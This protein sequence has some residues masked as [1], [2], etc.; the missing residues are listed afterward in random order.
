M[1]FSS[2]PAAGAAPLQKPGAPTGHAHL[3]APASPRSNTS[4]IEADNENVDEVFSNPDTADFE[5]RSD[6]TGATSPGP[7]SPGPSSPLSRSVLSAAMASKSIP[8]LSASSPP[9]L[10]LAGIGAVP[11]P[12]SP[13]Q[14]IRQAAYPESAVSLPATTAP[15]SPSA[16]AASSKK[17]APFTSNRSQAPS[18][19]SS[20]SA[21][22]SLPSAN[23]LPS[24]PVEASTVSRLFAHPPAPSPAITPAQAVSPPRT[25]G[26]SPRA[27]ASTLLPLGSPTIE[28]TSAMARAPRAATRPSSPDSKIRSEVSASAGSAAPHPTRKSARPT[29]SSS[30]A[31]GLMGAVPSVPTASN[32]TLPAGNNSSPSIFERDIE[33]RDAGHIMSQQEA[34]DV[35]IPSVLDDAVEA[36][37]EDST[38]QIEIVAPQAPPPPLALSS[39]A[40]SV[41]SDASSSVTP[42]MSPAPLSSSGLVEAPPGSIAA[43]IAERLGT[44]QP[45]QDDSRQASASSRKSLGHRRP[46]SDVSSTTSFRSRSPVAHRG[47][48][49]HEVFDASPVR[50]RASASP[51]PGPAASLAAAVSQATRT[52]SQIASA[53]LGGSAMG[54]TT[55]GALSPVPTATAFPS[56]PLPNPY[57]SSSPNLAVIN[58]PLV[59]TGSDAGRPAASSVSIDGA[60]ISGSEVATMDQSLDTLADVIA[61]SEAEEAASP[62]VPRSPAV[63]QLVSGS[64]S[65]VLERQKARQS[66]F[67]GTGLGGL[68]SLPGGLGV[69]DSRDG[70]FQAL[71]SGTPSPSQEKRRL[72]FFSYADILNQNPGEVMDFE[73]A[74]RQAAERDEQ[75]HGHVPPVTSIQT[76]SAASHSG[77]S[78]MGASGSSMYRSVST[79]AADSPRRASNMKNASASGATTPLRGKRDVLEN[80]ALSNRIESLNLAAEDTASK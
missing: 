3:L 37:I 8:E 80:R 58:T 31:S 76:G 16:T 77:L 44:R 27:A 67:S 40:L 61:A 5:Y 39:A 60:V 43:Q 50:S 52:P 22:S 24:D 32:L 23:E 34:I 66:R 6:G 41:H 79:S 17:D 54:L 74:I 20:P 72:S 53:P 45:A 29:S 25:P 19:P 15:Q 33:H 9:M 46:N 62:Y 36:I 64:A 28:R 12:V 69:F 48:G 11:K 49:T 57:R 51:T 59:A 55:S 78:A 68:G 71:A 26:L 10:K 75:Q 7:N 38:E 2:T 1:V 30:A 56:L 4:E 14:T 73:G 18:Y 70:A 63:P 13:N 35:A 21:M 47:A 65:P 42:A